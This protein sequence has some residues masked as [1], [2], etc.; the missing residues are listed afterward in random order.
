[1]KCEI[2]K[3]INLTSIFDL[4]KIPLADEIYKN[5][6]KSLNQ[7]KFPVK[8]FK[9]KNCETFYQSKI[10]NK[11]KLFHKNYHY[12]ARFTNDVLQGMK[13]L[14]NEVEQKIGPIKSKKVLDIGCNDGSLLDFFLKKKAKTYG[15]EPTNAYKDCKKK[16]NVTNKFFNIKVAKEFKKK[17]GCPDIIVFTNVFAHIENLNHLLKSLKVLIKDDTFIVIE[18]HYLLSVLKKMQFDTFYHEHLRTYSLMSFFQ[19]AKKLE[20]SIY[21]LKFPNRYGGNIRVIFGSIKFKSIKNIHKKIS[22]EK[23]KIKFFEKRFQKRFS[24]WKNAILKKI[25]NLNTKHG[26]LFGKAY[27]ARASLIINLL[28]LDSKNISRIYEK[29]GSKK[30][31]YYVPGTD[32]KIISDVYLNNSKPIINFSWHISKEIE[33]YLR[34]MRISQK[35]IDII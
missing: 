17:F 7:K 20:M 6:K 13:S 26:P 23:K 12:R 30:I 34:K 35:I 29:P 14:V 11:K 31:G 27:P 22:L 2:C 19:I 9:C 18:N 15:I 4:G 24:N 10:L 3:E 33:N 21:H 16:H 28:N 1:M 8:I 5:K 32:I 25:K